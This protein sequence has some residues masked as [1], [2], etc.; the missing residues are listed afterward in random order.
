[1][2]LT[3]GQWGLLAFLGSR[4]G[5]VALHQ[6]LVMAGDEASDPQQAGPHAIMVAVLTVRGWVLFPR[7]C[8][9]ESLLGLEEVDHTLQDLS[10]AHLWILHVL[11]R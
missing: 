10:F 9:L 6:L 8:P 7:H 11:T 2:A 5:A 3:Q 1:M 4:I